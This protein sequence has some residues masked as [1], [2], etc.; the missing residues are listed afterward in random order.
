MKIDWYRFQNFGMLAQHVTEEE[1]PLAAPLNLSV[2]KFRWHKNA[3]M[4]ILP[5]LAYVYYVLKV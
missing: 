1:E 3:Y 4:D 2:Q 5:T